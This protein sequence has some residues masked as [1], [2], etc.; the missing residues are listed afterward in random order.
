MV[1]TYTTKTRHW[2]K[3]VIRRRA[4]RAIIGFPKKTTEQLLDKYLK[5][6][7]NISLVQGCLQLIKGAKISFNS[8]DT[9]VITFPNK[10]F[11]EIART[12]TYGTGKLLGSQILKEA[13]QNKKVGGK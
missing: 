3:E 12:I 8:E 10:K 11:N 1:L 5:Q 7:Y 9:Y 4:Y 2:A 13:F 6:E